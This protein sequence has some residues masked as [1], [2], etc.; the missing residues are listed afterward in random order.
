MNFHWEFLRFQAAAELE[1]AAAYNKAMETSILLGHW[2]NH[3]LMN[4]TNYDDTLEGSLHSSMDIHRHITAS[5]SILDR[6]IHDVPPLQAPS[7]PEGYDEPIVE[8]GVEKASECALSLASTTTYTTKTTIE[9]TGTN[10]DEMSVGEGTTQQ[11]LALLRDAGVASV[12][13]QQV[14]DMI[15]SKQQKTN[16]VLLA[17]N[18]DL[19]RDFEIS[20]QHQHQQQEIQLLRRAD[21]MVG[22]TIC[23]PF[24]L[25]CY[26]SLQANLA[27]VPSPQP[28]TFEPTS[29]IFDGPPALVIYVTNEP[30]KEL[31]QEKT[32]VEEGQEAAVT[33]TITSGR[34]PA[35]R[36]RK[37][38]GKWQHP[39]N[40][41]V[42]YKDHHG[43]TLVVQK[44]KSS[45]SS[46]D[47]A[48]S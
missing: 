20:R 36:T 24:L 26:D 28:F 5:A 11:E 1:F 35:T 18:F 29:G 12:A 34:T 15:V 37:A 2:E 21:Q 46:H 6:S 22:T 41:L 45:Q 40:K 32:K 42:E 48:K 38:R 7:I 47:R 10:M 30:P 4:D 39:Y 31:K 8:I 3:L 25:P 27:S 44:C 19:I 17:D 9:T 23:N 13:A 16:P 14:Q 43:N 33:S